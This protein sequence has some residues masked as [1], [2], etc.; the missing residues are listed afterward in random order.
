MKTDVGSDSPKGCSRS[1]MTEYFSSEIT[2]IC[3]VRALGERLWLVFEQWLNKAW[4]CFSS[5]VEFFIS[6]LPSFAN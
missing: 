1:I 4:S 6:A 3:Y 5:F 2:F